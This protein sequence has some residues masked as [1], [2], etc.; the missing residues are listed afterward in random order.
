LADVRAVV[1]RRI[2][3]EAMDQKAVAEG[4]ATAVPVASK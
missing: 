3:K 1:R 4:R 2:E